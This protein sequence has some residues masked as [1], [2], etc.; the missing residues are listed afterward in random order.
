MHFSDIFLNNRQDW[1]S[2]KIDGIFFSD[3]L[4]SASI[5]FLN[6]AFWSLFTVYIL[7]AGGMAVLN[8]AS[9]GRAFRKG[10][11][12]WVAVRMILGLILIV[13][14]P[15]NSTYYSTGQH[16]AIGCIKIGSRAATYVWT[17]ALE[18]M[19]D[20]KPLTPV[21]P[22]KALEFAHQLFS[23]SICVETQNFPKYPEPEIKES[24]KVYKDRE[25]HSFNGDPA[26]GGIPAQC[27]KV[28][29]LKADDSNVAVQEILNSQ[30]KLTN[31]LWY[32]I[33]SIARQFVAAHYP[34]RNK[35]S[36]P[37]TSLVPLLNDY[38]DGIAKMASIKFKPNEK[39]REIFFEEAKKGGW[40]MAGAWAYQLASLNEVVY[41]ALDTLSTVTPPR[42]DWWAGTARVWERHK[43]VF[44]LAE[45]WWQE[46][47]AGITEVK[48]EAF[49]AFKED[50]IFSFFDFARI[51]WFY[52]M[53]LVSDRTLNPIDKMVSL[54]HAIINT[55]W[56]ALAAKAS[57]DVVTASIEGFAEKSIWGKAANFFTGV[58]AILTKSTGAFMAAYVPLFWLALFSL[59]GGGIM[60]AYILPLIPFRLWIFGVARYIVRAMMAVLAA[61]L[62]AI[63]H[64]DS[65]GEGI[66]QRASKGYH[67]LLEI[68]LR[69]LL[70]VI[71]L[72]AGFIIITL[73][74]ELFS[75]IFR[76]AIK[77][78]LIGSHGGFTG[79]IV[80]IV[81][82][83]SIFIT[84]VNISFSAISESIDF[85]FELGGMHTPQTASPERD[86]QVLD[87]DTE[88]STQKVEGVMKQSASS[89]SAGYHS[90]PVTNEQLFPPPKK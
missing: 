89:P 22:P 49:T 5:G 26:M 64:V 62:W 44:A 41:S 55:A 14:V 36:M 72:L 21:L 27:G 40:V 35:G 23:I 52:D 24:I 73:L 48:D 47:Q 78:A 29:A 76:I 12:V 59:I 1:L 18:Q 11:E 70:M 67:V 37:Q 34:L 9:E 77:N 68:L 51:K 65:H 7:L 2:Q 82:G 39:Q 16:V 75:G 61:P 42:Y 84:L 87:K 31:T 33:H 46:Q 83:T 56:A 79:L 17:K 28:V 3:N 25:V 57:A 8:S 90:K 43:W 15:H 38:G 58:P 50:S 45:K 53:T 81:L 71:G 69:P 88:Q 60:L 32:K 4:L 10:S 86:A 80:Y 19:K 63:A 85:C 30:I 20:L 54:G 66:G 74:G 13:P 6:V